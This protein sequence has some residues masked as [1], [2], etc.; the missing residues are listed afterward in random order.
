MKTIFRRLKVPLLIIF[1]L[2]VVSIFLFPVGVIYILNNGNPYTNYLINKSLPPYL[3]QKGYS[4]ENIL[5]QHTVGPKDTINKSYYH[6]RYM[7]IFKDEPNVSYYY[8]IKKRGKLIKQFCEK[9]VLV[10]GYTTI[11]TEQTKHSEE[12]CVSMYANR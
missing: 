3:E 4:D 5:E 9:D 8:G 10:K 6:D 11:N 7:V 1:L 12:K 2:L